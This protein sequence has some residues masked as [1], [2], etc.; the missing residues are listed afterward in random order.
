MRLLSLSCGNIARMPSSLGQYSR[1]FGKSASMPVIICILVVDLAGLRCQQHMLYKTR[2]YEQ[3][4]KLCHRNKTINALHYATRR[5]SKT[6]GVVGW[7][8]LGRRGRKWQFSHRAA[9][10][11]QRKLWVHR[12]SIFPE[13][14]PNGGFAG[15]T[16]Y[17]WKK[18]F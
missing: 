5:R 9:N 14:H 10:L 1:N 15:P 4:A 2:K 8:K 18:I 7:K 3:V 13:F 17:F 6:S 12:I 11:K 16:L